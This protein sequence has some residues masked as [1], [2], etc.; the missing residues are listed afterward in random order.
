MWVVGHVFLYPGPA[1]DLLVCWRDDEK[2]GKGTNASHSN[3]QRKLRVP[4]ARLEAF[5]TCFC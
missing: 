5:Q 3:G 4:G 2:A 1:V